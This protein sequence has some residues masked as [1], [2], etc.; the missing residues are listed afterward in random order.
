MSLAAL[1]QYEDH[2]R[3]Q[4]LRHLIPQRA[5]AHLGQLNSA[6]YGQ[7]GEKPEAFHATLSP[8]GSE[9]HLRVPANKV[10]RDY[11]V[12]L[13]LADAGAGQLELSFI[14]INDLLSPRFDIDY[15]E[16]GQST[17]MGTA[18]R[19][20]EQ[21]KL[22]LA[23]GLGPCQVRSGLRLFSE[24]LP[25]LEAFAKDLGYVAIQLEPLTYHNA[26]MYENYGFA[27]ITGRKQMVKLNKLFAQDGLLNQACNDSNVFRQRAFANNP[28][29][30]SWAIHDGVLEEMGEDRL[31][32]HMVKVIGKHAGQ[33]TFDAK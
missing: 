22:A 4:R 26:V 17:M 10:E 2:E 25:R 27:Y 12:L 3:D 8:S 11:A 16:Q 18:T 19:N 5:F 33:H 21:E 14:V 24:M 20:V 32:L 6:D 1:F 7:D 9:L 30:R 13:D 29:G 15:D 23:A 31:D 28:R